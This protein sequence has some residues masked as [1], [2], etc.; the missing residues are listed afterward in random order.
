MVVSGAR[1]RASNPICPRSCAFVVDKAA[2]ALGRIERSTAFTA[3][4]RTIQKIGRPKRASFKCASD[5][6]LPHELARSALP[7]SDA[8]SLARAPWVHNDNF[9]IKTQ[10]L[11]QNSLRCGRSGENC[12]VRRGVTP[13]GRDP[14]PL[15]G[16]AL[17]LGER[18]GTKGDRRKA[19]LILEETAEIGCIPE[20]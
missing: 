11:F 13:H 14:N 4:T 15:I 9:D 8:I 2:E 12:R 5:R 16:R 6:S 7:H 1:G 10:F 19:G 17:G 3:W 18:F 20:A